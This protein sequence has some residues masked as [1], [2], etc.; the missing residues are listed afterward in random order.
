MAKDGVSTFAKKNTFDRQKDLIDRE[1]FVY[2]GSLLCQSRPK[3]QEHPIPQVRTRPLTS[4]K[5]NVKRI[6]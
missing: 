1:R 3:T 6:D 2:S 5:N 4:D